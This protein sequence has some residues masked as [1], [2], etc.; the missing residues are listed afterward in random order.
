MPLKKIIQESCK[1]LLKKKKKNKIDPYFY[2]GVLHRI[3]VSASSTPYLCTTQLVLPVFTR[4]A[5]RLGVRVGGFLTIHELE[6]L[7]LISD[8]EYGV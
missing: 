5:T 6:W 7:V 3:A 8:E 2:H 4:L 1:K